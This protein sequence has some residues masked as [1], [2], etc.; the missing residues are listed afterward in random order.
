MRFNTFFVVL[1][2]ASALATPFKRDVATVKADIATI[3]TQVNALDT[4]INAFP[5]TGGT[6]ASALAIH[7]AAVTLD[8]SVKKA[9]TD[10]Q[11][12][13][14]FSE[15]DGQSILSS[16]EAIEPTILDALNG[17]V[18]KKAA[19]QALPIGGIPALVLQ[20]LKNLNTDTGA[21]ADAL[22][23]KS[24]ADLVTQANQI[25]TTIANAFATA[26]AAYS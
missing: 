19:F 25:K 15:A 2:A 24:P 4:S 10:T 8:T 26:I 6:L 23:A 16:V 5:N 12:T 20:D 1:S 17:I 22:I 11:A 7:N 21:F 13:S 3:S 18:A 9:V 14:A